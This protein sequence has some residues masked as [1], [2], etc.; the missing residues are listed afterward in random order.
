MVL[1]D[2]GDATKIMHDRTPICST[3]CPRHLRGD[4]D[5]VHRLYEMM[6]DGHA[7]GAG[8]QRQ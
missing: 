7:Q 6:R 1:D 4:D 3:A 8:V 5:G 2:G